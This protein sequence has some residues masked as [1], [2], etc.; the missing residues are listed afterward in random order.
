MAALFNGKQLGKPGD[1][2]AMIPYFLITRAD[3]KNQ[4]RKRGKIHSWHN[5]GSVARYNFIL[6]G[7]NDEVQAY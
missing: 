4:Q 1:S 7:I 6:P 5:S 2:R 3:P